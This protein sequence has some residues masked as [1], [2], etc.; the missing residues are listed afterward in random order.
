[1]K[2]GE[3]AVPRDV[4]VVL[5]ALDT[6]GAQSEHVAAWTQVASVLEVWAGAEGSGSGQV[7]VVAPLAG[8][9]R[10]L[11]V[12]VGGSARAWAQRL[13]SDSKFMTRSAHA[14]MIVAMD[15]AAVAALTRLGGDHV[16]VQ[17]NGWPVGAPERSLSALEVVAAWDAQLAAIDTELRSHTTRDARW[18]AVQPLLAHLDTTDI[19]HIP[20]ALAP[21]PATLSL[22]EAAIRRLPPQLVADLVSQ[23]SQAYS[24]SAPSWIRA[25]LRAWQLVLAYPTL[26]EPTEAE[27]DEAFVDLM[28]QVDQATADGQPE[29]GLALLAP[30]VALRFHRSRHSNVTKSPLTDQ[31]RTFLA[32]LTD[33]PAWQHLTDDSSPR[34]GT[35]ST[36]RPAG[37]A[38]GPARVLVLPG[39]HGEF[40][41]DV[42]AAL[43]GF[44]AVTVADTVKHTEF[45]RQRPATVDFLLIRALRQ[46]RVDLA[47]GT[48]DGQEPQTPALQ[49]H[50]RR[51]AKLESQM[52]R[53][54]VIFADWAD[55]ATMWA[56]QLC[57]KGVRLVVRVHSL[58]LLDAWLHLIDWR[59][60]HTLLATTPAMVSLTDDLTAGRPKHK[61]PQ[62]VGP[63][64]PDFATWPGDKPADAS[65]TLGMVGWG[66]RVKRVDFALDLLDRDPSRNLIL[67]GP[68]FG[69]STDASIEEYAGVANQRIADLG[70]RV[71]VVGQTEDVAG[72]LRRVG[73]ILS[74]SN[75]EGWHLGLMEGAAAGAVPVVRDW[76]LLTSHGGARLQFPDEWVIEDV[77]QADERIRAVQA[78]GWSEA[79][80][81]S[82]EQVLRLVDAEAVRERTI[83][84]V[85]RK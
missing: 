34:P 23:W 4:N 12:L 28:A 77:A 70:D 43:G 24:A 84:L 61:T 2:T 18:E 69:T 85:L 37:Q 29:L 26:N 38:R 35:R 51:L 20:S 64:R 11:S 83:H 53:H 50:L 82:R 9:R 15:S 6:P 46:G 8:M 49:T 72:H 68:G 31:T 52:K 79:S 62:L 48:I 30:A 21:W 74:A 1:M 81:R 25:A 65:H 14:D 10:V 36:R 58:D 60:V 71:E 39:A 63:Y 59:G 78:S 45:S 73:F 54:D 66:R 13:T 33:A 40:H 56:S 5:L 67:I 55:A 27:A 16:I 42:I 32:P 76:S 7:N 3:L 19:S 22:A 44:A 47:A 75:R 80:R 57:P 17:A 41:R